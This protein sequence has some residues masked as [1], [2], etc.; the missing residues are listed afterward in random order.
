MV[1]I[2]MNIND[3]WFYGGLNC[4]MSSFI[5]IG[6][7]VPEN[8]FEGFLPYGHGINIGHVTERRMLTLP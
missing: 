1:N 5:A 6:S 7:A 4:Y 2:K 3:G 8:I